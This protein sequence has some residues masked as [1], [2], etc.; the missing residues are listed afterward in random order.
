[1]F[2][3]YYLRS[4]KNYVIEVGYFL[5]DEGAFQQAIQN[6]NQASQLK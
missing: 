2:L 3:N 6:F 4:V 1:V 5:P